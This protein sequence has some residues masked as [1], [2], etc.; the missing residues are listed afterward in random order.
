MNLKNI[1]FPADKIILN[2]R[3]FYIVLSNAFIFSALDLNKGIQS[4]LLE[5]FIAFCFNFSACFFIFFILSFLGKKVFNFVLIF[6]FFVHFILLLV[7][8]FLIYNFSTTLTNTFFE[9]F[10][11]TNKRET[12]EF[13]QFYFNFNNS[14]LILSCIFISILFYKIKFTFYCPSILTVILLFFSYFN[15]FFYTITS[16]ANLKKNLNK[17]ALYNV[18]RIIQIQ[19]H[20][21][22]SYIQIVKTFQTH[23]DKMLNEKQ[24]E[25]Y[26]YYENNENKI[27]KIVL[28]IGESTQRNYMSLYNYSLNTTPNLKKLENKN[29]LFV[30][31]DVVAPNTDTFKTLR[32]VLTFANQQNKKLWHKEMNI[33]DAMKLLNYQTLWFSN[34]DADAADSFGN[35]IQALARRSDYLEYS[36]YLSA[37]ETMQNKSPKDAVL[38]KMYQNYIQS[39]PPPKKTKSICCFSFNGRTLSI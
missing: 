15:F 14:V 21:E 5:F 18:Y 27:P 13:I 8:V 26:I 34:Q 30:F 7:N 2:L 10:L 25:N 1:C 12:W 33:I 19:S 29:E 28:I 32:Q 23:L 20:T 17:I 3:F 6:L 4:F 35:A 37:L 9:I 31:K 36:A 38:I 22:T 39:P 24:K 16:N 11:S